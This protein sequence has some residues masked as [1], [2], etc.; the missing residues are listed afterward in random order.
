MEQKKYKVAVLKGTQRE[1][2]DYGSTTWIASRITEFYEVSEEDYKALHRYCQL[3]DYRLIEPV[4]PE[5]ILGDARKV[6]AQELER[7]RK[8]EAEAETRKK[9]AAAARKKKLSEAEA[10]KK[11][12]LKTLA[13]EAGYQLVPK[14]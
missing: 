10:K 3:Y 7:R 8:Y 5:D 2:D 4:P 12:E 13:E 14:T 9:R 6:W 11:L 1:N